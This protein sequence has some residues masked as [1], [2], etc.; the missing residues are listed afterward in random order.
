MPWTLFAP[1]EESKHSRRAKIATFWLIVL[2]WLNLFLAVRDRSETD[3]IERGVNANNLRFCAVIS[4][5]INAS[6]GN[7]P[8]TPYGK[9]QL[10]N[11]KDLFAEFDCPG[12]PED[13]DG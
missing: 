3:R 13:Y 6:A 7:P 8:A 5:T 1:N 10:Q 9:R 12:K 11:F 4:T 2:T